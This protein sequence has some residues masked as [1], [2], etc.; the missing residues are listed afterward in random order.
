[1]DL[2]K[3]YHAEIP[4]HLE[5][6]A[7]TPLMQRLKDIGMNCGCE[8]TNFPQFQMCQSYSR[9]DHSLGVALIIWHFTESIQQSIAGLLHDIST[10]T[11]AHVI[12]FMNGDYLKQ[13]FTETDTSLMIKSDP[14]ITKILL[15]YG[16]SPRDVDDYHKFPVADNDLPKLSA[17]RLEYT[18]GNLVNYGLQ[19]KEKV[20]Q[21]YNDIIVSQNEFGLPEM[22]FR[23]RD[24]AEAFSKDALKCSRIYTSDADRFSM[25]VLA[26]ILNKAMDE[27][28]INETDLYMTESKVIEKLC[29]D[30]IYRGKWNQ[31][32]SYR[33]II[34][35]QFPLSDN[36]WIFVTAKKRYIDPFVV[37]S[38]RLASLSREYFEELSCYQ[39]QSF[40]Y[41]MCGIT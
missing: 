9:Y 28:V 29:S 22:A 25:Q 37:G 8:Y 13:E 2:W 5:K 32:C 10:P 41:W 20:Q 26:S 23:H 38:G 24:I 14:Y 21:Y 27:G 36:K 30:K 12:D 3:I 40:N 11:F 34:T 31:Y 4:S 39:N 1:M 7:K 6:I 16:L 19:T 17:D 15:E 35:S 33:S 18:L